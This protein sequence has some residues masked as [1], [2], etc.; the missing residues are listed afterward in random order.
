MRNI[1][2]GPLYIY[3]Y[4]CLYE[5]NHEWFG[6]QAEFEK[7]P[8]VFEGKREEEKRKNTEAEA[9]KLRSLVYLLCLWKS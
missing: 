6:A 8:K 2:M 4:I 9:R 1:D 7:D 5:E 3:L